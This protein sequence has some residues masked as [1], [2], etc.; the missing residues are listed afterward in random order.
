LIIDPGPLE[1]SGQSEGPVEL[2]GPGST[3]FDVPDAEY[4]LP[5][6]LSFD[7]PQAAGSN[8][9]K[10]T[11]TARTVSLGNLYT[12]SVGRLIV[13]GG[14]GDAGSVTEPAVVIS[15]ITTTGAPSKN[16]EFNGNSYFNNPGWFDDTGGGSID[17]AV[18]DMGD[19]SVQ[20][21]T[22]AGNELATAWVVVAPPKYAPTAYNIVSILDLQ[23]DLFPDQDPYQASGTVNFYRDIYPLLE[24][25]TD[26]AWTSLE[27]FHG[28]RPGVQGDFLR[29]EFLDLLA[30]PSSSGD[31]LDARNFVYNLI[32][33]P[34]E[35]PVPPVPPPPAPA[36]P[37]V[38][39]NQPPNGSLM[40]KLTGNGGSTAENAVNTTQFPNQWL[41]LTNHQLAKL[42]Q[43]NEG[44]FVAGTPGEQRW[45][46][47]PADQALNFAALQPT[48]GGGFHPG[49]ELT[50]LMQEASFFSGP[51][52]FAK[53]TL[54]GAI[55]GYMSVP[56]H[57]D[58]WS[59]NTTFWPAARPDIAVTRDTTTNP[60]G[61]TPIPWFRGST[62]PP[63]SD[64]IDGYND[65]YQ[66]MYNNWPKYGFVI[67]SPTQT[68]GGEQVF[69]EAE[70]DPGL[71]GPSVIVSLTADNSPDGTALSVGGSVVSVQPSNPAS[72]A[73]QWRLI[74]S[75]ISPSFFTIA[76]AATPGEVLTV[77]GS[78]V[79]LG[80]QQSPHQDQQ[81][82]QY[83]PSGYPGAFFLQS[84]FDAGLLLSLTS[85]SATTAAEGAAN[86]SQRF[87]L[88]A[89][90]T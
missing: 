81:L 12:D 45:A 49:I 72:S 40:P 11:Y 62:V 18:I 36:P 53:G 75:S 59:C 42:K 63:Q 31:A 4:T 51:F 48:V 8:E 20:L 46:N 64:A 66:T 19:P 80:A 69:V 65:G 34:A 1:I 39:T 22:T 43:W 14:S 89:S 13:V 6:T 26:Y 55:S 54:P 3:I 17:A 44:N 56:W 68:D 67:P 77:S 32:R 85:T 50:Y 60:V 15:K 58:F 57:G 87:S 37:G 2:L 35:I 5:A 30:D 9:V 47:L 86:L 38:K 7:P 41:S 29:G 10:V 88:Q 73:Q 27:A 28:H 82:W 84:R 78:E 16:P 70:R 33:P 52:R 21:F 23:I 24:I 74:Q 90:P 25:V 83:I 76:S 71:D 79:I 61:L